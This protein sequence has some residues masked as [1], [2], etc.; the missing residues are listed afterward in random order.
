LSI[1]LSFSLSPFQ[2]SL[3]DE[4]D[5]HGGK[6]V[7]QLRFLGGVAPPRPNSVHALLLRDL[8]NHPHV[9]VVVRVLA[10]RDLLHF[11]V[12]K[13]ER[14][15][16]VGTRFKKKIAICQKASFIICFIKIEKYF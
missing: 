1:P 10:R 5:A 3:T 8:A 7:G 9:G 6:G 4:L 11:K 15:K 16:Q 12:I 14:E 2:S 13:K